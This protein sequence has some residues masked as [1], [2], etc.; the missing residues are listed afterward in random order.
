MPALLRVRCDLWVLVMSGDAE[1]GR[2]VIQDEGGP[3][4]RIRLYAHDDARPIGSILVRREHLALYA[5]WFLKA[6]GFTGDL[7]D[8]CG[9][10]QVVRNGTCL[11]CHAC[12]ATSGCS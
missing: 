12:G 8:M 11:L 4:V 5:L 2:L 1:I 7:C 9:S 3:A 10:A 6:S